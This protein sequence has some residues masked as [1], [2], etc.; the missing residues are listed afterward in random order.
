MY[1]KRENLAEELLLREYIRKAINIVKNKR[2]KADEQKSKEKNELR[3]LIHKMIINEAKKI[4]QWDKTGKNELDRM[5]LTTNFLTELEG[6]YKSL[7]TT[8]QQR[9]SFKTHIIQ[10]VKKTLNLERVKEI[11]GDQSSIELTEDEDLNVTIDGGGLM[12]LPPEQEKEKKEED[13]LEEFK[14]E[15]EEGDPTGLRKAYTAFHNIKE[16]L[17]TYYTGMGLEED[18]EYFYDNLIEQ[19]GLYFIKWE[20]E[21]DPTPELPAEVEEPTVE[22]EPEE[23]PEIEI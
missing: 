14:V 11:P 7:T 16:T 6:A 1:T 3:N 17:M 21:L 9:D 20:D 22:L 10:N 2:R 15:G 18:R 5:F 12:G 19:L 23:A 4:P 13:E 8:K